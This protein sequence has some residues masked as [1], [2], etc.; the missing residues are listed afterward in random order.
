MNL[1]SIRINNPGSHYSC[2]QGTKDGEAQGIVEAEEEVSSAKD[3]SEKHE[4]TR[5]NKKNEK[6]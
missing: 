5:G 3:V 6:K 1:S 2:F 4:S